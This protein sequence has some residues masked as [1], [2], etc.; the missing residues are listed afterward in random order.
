MKL[1]VV[2][3][4]HGNLEAFKAVLA[5][6]E[7]LGVDKIVSLGDL[8]C[9][10]N[11]YE[12]VDLALEQRDKGKLGACLLGNGDVLDTSQFNLPDEAVYWS[13][14]RREAALTPQEAKR[15]NFLGE[16]PRVWQEGR[17][18]FVHGSP[19]NP[20]DE[21]VYGDDAFDADKMSALFDAT[22]RYCFQG[23][24][25]VPGVFVEETNKTYSY[26]SAAE[27]EGGVFPLDERKLMVNVGAVGDSREP[28]CY[29]VVYYEE[30][31]VDDKIE[32]RYPAS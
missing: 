8:A 3:D 24:T 5:D 23:H 7:A 28:S 18:L 31:G 32:F 11:A 16:A 2:S 13:R 22:P 14:E 30:S 29:V 10:P 20:R 17:F 25:H 1:A 21:Y 15:W 27:L 6:A 26:Y 19:R 4:V 12:C 9:G